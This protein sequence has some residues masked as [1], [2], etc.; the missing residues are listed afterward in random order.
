V[1]RVAASSVFT[2]VLF[3]GTARA[4]SA[5]RVRLD[6][7]GCARLDAAAVSRIFAADLG[8]ASTDAEGPDVTTATVECEGSH[9]VIRVLDP[10]SRKTLRRSFDSASFGNQG[11][12]RLVA[13]AASELVLASWAEL[14]NNPALRVEPEG[15]PPTSESLTTARATVREH[16][17]PG[18]AVAAT[19]PAPAGPQPESPGENAADAP[20]AGEEAEERTPARQPPTAVSPHLWRMVALGSVRGFFRDYG[21]LTGGMARVGEDRDGIMSWALDMTIEQGR[22]EDVQATSTSLGA[23]LYA[24]LRKDALVCRLGA[25]VRPGI[26]TTGEATTVATWGWPFGSAICSMI[27]GPFVLELGGEVGYAVLEHHGPSRASLRAGWYSVNFGLG[28]T[29]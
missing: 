18:P 1:R 13:I 15:P 14:S 23:S 7:G 2:L 16:T 19:P 26:L 3:T 20:E 6:L 21:Y 11:E 25:G 9:V 4:A 22:I 17:R 29:L 8:A 28:L 12:A 5:P 27:P 24:H 10:L